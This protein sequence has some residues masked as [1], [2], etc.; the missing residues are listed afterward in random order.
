M[1][2]S[3]IAGPAKPIIAVKAKA[4]HVPDEQVF[5]LLSIS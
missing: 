1:T 2:T 5:I 3:A 4:A